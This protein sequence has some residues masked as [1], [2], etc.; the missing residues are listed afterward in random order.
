MKFYTRLNIAITTLKD[1]VHSQHD[2][3]LS[4][5]RKI[6]EWFQ[7]KV[8]PLYPQSVEDFLAIKF[9]LE[10]PES[11]IPITRES[12]SRFVHCVEKFTYQDRNQ[13]ISSVAGL[14]NDLVIHRHPELLDPFQGEYEYYYCPATDEI[15]LCGEIGGSI[16]LTGQMWEKDASL[17]PAKRSTLLL[18]GILPESATYHLLEMD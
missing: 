6:R 9:L 2:C 4:F 8:L 16:T 18:A 11:E 12:C 1:I 3:N 10:T 13:F 7:Q 5:V 17:F 15:I 14:I